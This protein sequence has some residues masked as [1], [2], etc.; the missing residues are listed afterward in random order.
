M[1]RAQSI[2]LMRR[3]AYNACVRVKEQPATILKKQSASI[4]FH[5]GTGNDISRPIA[6]QCSRWYFSWML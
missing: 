3:N 2:D 1:A 4:P 6:F 5:K